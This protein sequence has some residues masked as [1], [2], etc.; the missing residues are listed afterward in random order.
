MKLIKI[1]FLKFTQRT[2]LLQNPVWSQKALLV[3]LTCT[4]RADR[5][6]F[7]ALMQTS[8]D[9]KDGFQ[10]IVLRQWH[11]TYFPLAMGNDRVL[12]C[13]ILDNYHQYKT[14]SLIG[15]RQVLCHINKRIKVTLCHI[16]TGSKEVPFVVEV[17][18]ILL[19]NI[20]ISLFIFIE[21]SC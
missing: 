15:H 21:V 19:L 8:T 14:P 5:S 18:N 9:L 7:G 3:A 10:M 2:L 20:E 4:V 1:R 6:I 12:V 16:H 17:A 13:L 11:L